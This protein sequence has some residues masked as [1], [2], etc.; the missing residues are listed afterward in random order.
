MYGDEIAFWGVEDGSGSGTSRV[1]KPASA[2]TS[3]VCTTSGKGWNNKSHCESF[4]ICIFFKSYR[5][6]K[7]LNG[8]MLQKT[9]NTGFAGIQI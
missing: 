8:Q 4:L 7:Y 6:A 1:S 5:G 2:T 3:N 9:I